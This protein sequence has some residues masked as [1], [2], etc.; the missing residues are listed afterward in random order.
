M[1]QENSLHPTEKKRFPLWIAIIAV[2]VVV[3]L[4]AVLALAMRNSANKSLE[5]GQ[6]IPDFTITSYT[7]E[8]Y[9]KSD[10]A[11]KVILVNFWSSWCASCDEEG[12]AL[13]QVWKEVKDS[14]DVV[15]IGVNYVDTEKEALAF[16]EQ[17]NV[18]YPNGPDLGSRI[19][20][21]FKVEAVPETYI[22][23]RDGNLAGIMIGPFLTP[24][25]VHALLDPIMAQ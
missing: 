3:G 18:T 1:E 20:T 17:Y 12:E 10:L 22:I 11:G 19:S 4:L 5:P 9:R 7:G 2:A 6:K 15:F 23:G 8:T 24:E 21:L 14:G 13:E 16:L 25:D